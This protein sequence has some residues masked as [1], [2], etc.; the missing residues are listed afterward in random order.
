MKTEITQVYAPRRGR[1]R[2]QLSWK[3]LGMIV[4]AFFYYDSEIEA[5]AAAERL[6]DGI[7]AERGAND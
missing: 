5:Q 4:P 7:R 1:H 3:S 6:R 2:F